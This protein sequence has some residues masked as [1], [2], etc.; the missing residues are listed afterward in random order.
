[1]NYLVYREAFQ[2]FDLGRAASAAYILLL[3]TLFVVLV[4]SVV[5]HYLTLRQGATT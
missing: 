2:S 3:V 5:R 1:M 4:M